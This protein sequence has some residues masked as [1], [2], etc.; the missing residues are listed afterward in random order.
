MGVFLCFIFLGATWRLNSFTRKCNVID[1]RLAG[2]WKR[3]QI[4]ISRTVFMGREIVHIGSGRLGLH[5]IKRW[6][7]AGLCCRLKQRHH[8]SPVK[9]LSLSKFFKSVNCENSCKCTWRVY[10]PGARRRCCAVSPASLYRYDAAGTAHLG[11]HVT[12]DTRSWRYRRSRP[13]PSRCLE[14]PLLE[15]LLR[16]CLLFFHLYLL[17][18]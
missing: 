17:H 15:A 2:C 9:M 8:A 7:E 16:S 12:C 5:D 4:R 18:L 14:E 11:T 3:A 6:H 1:G 13:T 10:W